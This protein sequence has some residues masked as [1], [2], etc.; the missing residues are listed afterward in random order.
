M[1]T[2]GSLNKPDIYVMGSSAKGVGLTDAE[3]DFILGNANDGTKEDISIRAAYTKEGFTKRCV[4]VRARTLAGM[5]FSIMQGGSVLYTHED[6]IPWDWFDPFGM[7]YRIEGALS[8]TA[9][10]YMFKEG[11][12][13]DGVFGAPEK[14]DGLK[15]LNPTTVIPNL[16][17]GPYGP[18]EH[19]DFTHFKREVNGRTFYVPRELIL[20][21]FT[22]D[23]FTEQGAGA[24][25]GDAARL[26]SQILTDLNQFSS[27]QLRS[28]L[29][30]KTVFVAEANARQ[31]DEHQ[32][33]RW[34]QYIKRF[35]LGPTGTPP[36]VMQG[37]D[38]KEIG[39]SLA[40]LHSNEL[41]EQAQKAIATSFGVP[42]SLV[43]SDA[44][45]YAT[46]QADRINFYETT[47]IPQAM[48]IQREM[49]RQLFSAM[50]LRMQ[51]EPSKLEAFQRAELE[52]AQAV[53][54][55]VGGPV[56]TREEGRAMLGYAENPEG[57]FVTPMAAVPQKE[58]KGDEEEAE[59]DVD[60]KK[61]LRNWRKVIEKH[62]RGAT[63]KC[64]ALKGYEEEEVRE[65]LIAGLGLDEVFRPPFSGF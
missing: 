11:R 2:M 40:D 58:E 27:D 48:L 12:H 1:G 14:I 21:V 46:A 61:E 28:G 42:H 39:A 49:N 47:V 53:F 8:L 59:M 62:G 63:F 64:H 20:S 10:A 16:E 24:A 38:T 33:K 32:M 26:Y 30:R 44:A 18:D 52:K 23:P 35:L 41:S 56:L 19:G 15:W 57:E 60:A 3:W 36:E 17:P 45:N 7:L 34:R 54:Q 31:P 51:F 65:R 55:L 50:G 13:L 25:D 29:V 43:M 6:D 9:A 5:P 4:D 22:P 37:L